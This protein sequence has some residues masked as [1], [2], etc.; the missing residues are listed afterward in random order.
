MSERTCSLPECQRPHSGRGWCAAH[1]QRWRRYGDPLAEDPTYALRRADIEVRFLAKVEKLSCGCWRWT[2]NCQI[3]NGERSYGV[4]KANGSNRQSHRW[5]YEH[6]IGPIPEGHHI[7]HFRFPQDG[8]IGPSCVNPEHLRIAT[9]RENTL[10]SDSPTSWN[11]S[12]T[13]C[14]QGH[15]Y[16]GFNLQVKRTGARRC[17]TCSRREMLARYH[18]RMGNPSRP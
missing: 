18:R 11:A 3:R 10:R 14:P 9:P 2:G 13:H 1:Y 4:F 15:L 16:A 6:W 7:D 8:C 17:R 5:A 12:R